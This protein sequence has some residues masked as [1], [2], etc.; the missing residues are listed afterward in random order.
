MPS[1]RR[2]AQRRVSSSRQCWPERGGLADIRDCAGF[3]QCH[4]GAHG[5]HWPGVCSRGIWPTAHAWEDRQPVANPH[6][7]VGVGGPG[8]PLL[9]EPFQTALTPVRGVGPV[10]RT[11]RPGFLARRPARHSAGEFTGSMRGITPRART[12]RRAGASMTG[13]EHYRRAEEF[14]AEAHRL[15]GQGDGQATVGASGRRG[16]DPCGARPGRRDRGR[17]IRCGYPRLGDTAGTGFGSG[18]GDH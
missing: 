4:R 16:P 17:R 1:E 2:L 13:P 8:P 15:L 10:L 5:D 7:A 14:A 9:S 11:R 3:G 6:R 18:R 12:A